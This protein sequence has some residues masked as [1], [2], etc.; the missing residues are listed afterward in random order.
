[1]KPCSKCGVDKDLSEFH[2]HKD[3]PDG[4]RAVCKS[5][6]SGEAKVYYAEH[7]EEHAANYASYRM[8]NAEKVSEYQAAWHAKHRDRRIGEAR[9]RREQ[10]NREFPAGEMVARARARSKQLGIPFDLDVEDILIPSVC[11]VLGIPIF[12]K[13]GSRGP[14]PNSPSLDR[15]DPAGG[16]TKDNVVVISH[17]ANT[18]KNNASLDEMERVLAYMKTKP[19]TVERQLRACAAGEPATAPAPAQAAPTEPAA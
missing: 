2:R 14:G 17:R 15:F 11:P 16:Y 6:R 19:M 7:R 3:A 18:L 9:E 1:M 4:H 13:L 10:R 12:F 5:C 8:R